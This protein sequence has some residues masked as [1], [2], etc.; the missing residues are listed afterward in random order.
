M[1]RNDKKKSRSKV[2]EEDDLA[3]LQPLLEQLRKA[4]EDTRGKKRKRLSRRS[5][6]QRRN[7]KDDG[8]LSSS[9]SDSSPTKS[10][11]MGMVSNLTLKSQPPRQRRHMQRKLP[12]SKVP[13][14]TSS[15]S[16]SSDDDDPSDDDDRFLSSSSHDDNAARVRVA[17]KVRQKQIPSKIEKEKKH[18]H[19]NVTP[20][21]AIAPFPEDNDLS[22][23][24]EHRCRFNQR[25][26]GT[27]FEYDDDTGTYLQPVREF[28][29]N[30]RI[31]TREQLEDEIY[32]LR[33]WKNGDSHAKAPPKGQPD[34]RTG[35][36]FRALHPLGRTKK[37]QRREVRKIWKN[38]STQ[39]VLFDQGRRVLAADEREHHVSVG[40][41]L[42]EETT[43]NTLKSRFANITSRQ[44]KDYILGCPRCSMRKKEHHHIVVLSNPYVHWHFE[45]VSSATL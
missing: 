1:G 7:Y 42:C 23:I 18:Q 9:T 31:L 30:S 38:G 8:S 5:S 6:T 33:H 41:W 44:V 40:Y 19:Q 22:L 10:I 34:P 27:T 25:V 29:R 37:F 24:E 43:H 26:F 36:G 21:P 28:A 39:Y 4:N 13:Y 20:T 35:V 14:S 12:T 11:K 15:S 32:I 45:I 17:A 3:L 2:L 16:E